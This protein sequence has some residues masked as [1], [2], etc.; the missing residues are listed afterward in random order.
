M[1]LIWLAQMVGRSLQTLEILGSHPVIVKTELH[2]LT[3]IHF[4]LICLKLFKHCRRDL[5]ATFALTGLDFTFIEIEL[6]GIFVFEKKVWICIWFFKTS[7]CIY[8]ENI[9]A[10]IQPFTHFAA[11]L[12]L[13][14]I[15][16]TGS[17]IFNSFQILRLDRK[18]RTRKP[19]LKKKN[20]TASFEVREKEG[21]VR[22]TRS[23]LF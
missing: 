9:L 18:S 3:G 16:K 23:Q 6:N 22:Q 7:G 19:L 17:A 1:W 2:R 11:K 5:E 14:K 21:G 12:S 20:F 10:V 13:E 4:S 15:G 8:F